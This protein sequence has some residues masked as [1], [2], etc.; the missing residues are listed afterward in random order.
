MHIV[1]IKLVASNLFLLNKFSPQPYA[2]PHSIHHK[3]YIN[4]SL[5]KEKNDCYFKAGSFV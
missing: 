5:N 1:L 3:Y 2:W 4:R